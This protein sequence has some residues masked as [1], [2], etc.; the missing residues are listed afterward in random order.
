L[1]AVIVVES[2]NANA[3][4]I[5]EMSEHFDR[6]VVLDKT[7]HISKA[8]LPEDEDLILL[9]REEESLDTAIEKLTFDDWLIFLDSETRLNSEFEKIFS[10]WIFNPGCLYCFKN[11]SADAENKGE[12]LA[13]PE[14]KNS[15]LPHPFVLVNRRAAA[16]QGRGEKE[17]KR[18]IREILLS[19]PKEKIVFICSLKNENSERILEELREKE[20]QK[21]LSM[22][23]HILS[24]W[25]QF[26]AKYNKET[27]LYGAGSHTKWFL[28]KLEERQ[29]PLPCMIFDDDPD[30]LELSGVPVIKS[31]RRNE[32]K[33][34]A[35]LVSSDTYSIEMT[36]RAS[37]L[38]KNTDIDVVNPYSEFPDPQFQK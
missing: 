12:P 3:T 36:R 14:G 30:D 16:L 28:E 11:D 37:Q 25:R 19:W 13:F 27:A 8:S 6:A 34:K 17:K 20:K 15:C 18:P 31:E 35:L 38:W 9:S 10:S 5:L 21:T 26:Q 1:E 2:A 32:F 22:T 29:L 7:G 4:Q 23:E 33:L 24:F